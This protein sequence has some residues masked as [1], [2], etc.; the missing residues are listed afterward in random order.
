MALTGAGRNTETRPGWNEN[1]IQIIDAAVVR[2]GALTA[3]AHKN[4]STAANRGKATAFAASNLLIPFGMMAGGNKT[5]SATVKDTLTN[6]LPAAKLAIDRGVARLPVTGLTSAD[7]FRDVLREVW[8]SDDGTF[9][10]TRTAKAML[11]GYVF[12]PDTTTTCW[13]AL[14]L[15]L[16]QLIFQAAVKRYAWCLGVVSGNIAATGTVK[17]NIVAPHHGRVLDV[18]GYVVQVLQAAANLTINLRNSAVDFNGGVVTFVAADAQGARKQGTAVADDPL[19]YIHENDDIRLQATV[20][21]G[22]NTGLLELWATVGTELG[23]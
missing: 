9:S 10:L 12:L 14:V 8:A 2:R 6:Q 7:L 3:V 5:G 22:S 15:G 4:T 23:A 20:T 18:Y 16:D 13:V 21:A 11:A 19:N 17:T 1:L